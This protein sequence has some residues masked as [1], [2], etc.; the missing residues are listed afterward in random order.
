M[1]FVTRKTIEDFIEQN[2]ANDFLRIVKP[3]IEQ[4]GSE[5]CF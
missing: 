4:F 5:I 1:K 2:T 3:L